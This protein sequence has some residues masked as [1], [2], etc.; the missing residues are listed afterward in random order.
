MVDY[1]AHLRRSLRR[2]TAAGSPMPDLF[3]RPPRFFLDA[4]DPTLRSTV[5]DTFQQLQRDGSHLWPTLTVA[6]RSFRKLARAGVPL[7]P[8]GWVAHLGPSEGSA[9]LLGNYIVINAD[10]LGN[11]PSDGATDDLQVLRGDEATLSESLRFALLRGAASAQHAYAWGPQD[12]PASRTERQLY[13]RL[14]KAAA[15][16]LRARGS[17]E[18]AGD[19]AE[20]LDGLAYHKRLSVLRG[21]DGREAVIEALAWREYLHQSGALD[22]PGAPRSVL[23]IEAHELVPLGHHPGREFVRAVQER[24]QSPLVNTECAAITGRFATEL[25]TA[26]RE[27]FRSHGTD[28]THQFLQDWME[29]RRKDP[30][31]PD[32]SQAWWRHFGSGA[33]PVSSMVREAATLDR[34]A[35]LCRK[36]AA[37]RADATG[38]AAEGPFG[39]HALADAVAR[40]VEDPRLLRESLAEVADRKFWAEHGLGPSGCVLP[41]AYQP[42]P[43][44]AA[45]LE[46]A[47]R[48]DRLLRGSAGLLQELT[49]PAETYRPP[50]NPR[51]VRRTRLDAA[52]EEAEPSV[53]VDGTPALRPS[54]R[55]RGRGPTSLGGW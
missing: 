17:S 10:V 26:D 9:R 23:A 12:R 11:A 52:A 6:A 55:A 5:L 41:E 31:A 19:P 35:D 37:L 2:T 1:V 15:A 14:R 8:N 43:A 39:S 27:R 38:Q 18:V 16:D 13:N 32:L 44:S 54:R 3:Q 48:V 33:P 7:D 25:S 20:R 51:A 46:G 50:S 40:L 30:R 22:H 21:G 42:S 47:S 53:P 24:V 28:A 36:A 4:L 45:T 49:D 29:L 34:L